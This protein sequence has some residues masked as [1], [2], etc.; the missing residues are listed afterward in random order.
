IE[1]GDEPHPPCDSEK[2]LHPGHAVWPEPLEEGG[3]RLHYSGE[4]LDQFEDLPAE[5]LQ[6]DGWVLTGVPD[7]LGERLP[8]RVE[9]DAQR[10]PAA[11][12]VG[13]PVGEGGHERTPANG[14]ARA[15]RAFTPSARSRGAVRLLPH[16]Q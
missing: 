16:A 4:R 10:A 8:P 2:L 3:L 9:A 7:R 12:G 1:D 13:E 15:G 14:P 11:D 5:H 6:C